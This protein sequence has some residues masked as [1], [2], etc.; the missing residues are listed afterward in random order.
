[1]AKYTREELRSMAIKALASKARG[2]ADYGPKVFEL[3]IRTR[4]SIAR[5]ERNIEI[6]ARGG[7]V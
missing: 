3:A 4:L 5:V 7:S 1:M 6:L 2:D